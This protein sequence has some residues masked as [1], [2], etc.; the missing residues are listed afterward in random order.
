MDCLEKALEVYPGRVEKAVV[1]AER[2]AG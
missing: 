2:V 1:A